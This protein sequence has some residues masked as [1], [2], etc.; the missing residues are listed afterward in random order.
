LSV[1]ERACFRANPRYA[2]V[3]LDRLSSAERQLVGGL[4]PDAGQYGVLR[5]RPGSELQTRAVSA[6][7]ALLFLTLAEPGPLPNYVVARLG[8][9]TERTIGRLV[10]DGVLEM[11]HEGGY[12]SGAAAGDVV[13]P[14]RS[15]AGRG[16][17]GEL[18]RAALCYGQELLGLPEPLL[19]RRLY[20]YGHR[21]VDAGLRRRLNGDAALGAYLGLESGGS[22]CE[23]LDAGWWEIVAPQGGEGR[24][25][26]M[27][28]PRVTGQQWTDRVGPSYKLYVSPATGELKAAIRAV[29]ASLATVRG[30]LAFK[31][32]FSVAAICRPDKLIVYLDRLDDLQAG[33]SLLVE[34]LAGCPAHGVPF[35]AEIT[36][37][38]LL[39]WGADPPAR[40]STNEIEGTGWRLWVTR[41]LAE[42]LTAAGNADCGELEPW[43]RAL[44]R[45]RL[46]GIDPDTWIPTNGMWAQ[47][48]ALG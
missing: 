24:Y 17:I 13:A 26:R 5:P 43:Q 32:G 22:R 12:V 8:R 23:P 15:D 37:D 45:L 33:A 16:R 18:S 6:D 46:S 4:E 38:G 28:C 25:W 35:T 7:T 27:W 3:L 40:S 44:Q 41:R 31:V 9:E 48:L 2:L 30:V 1:I 36:R 11:E 20:G 10:L 42:Y 34:R 14:G 39:S 47:I 29:A 21:P 19:A